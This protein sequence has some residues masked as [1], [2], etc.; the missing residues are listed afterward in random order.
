[1]AGELKP[2]VV[3]MDLTLPRMDGYEAAPLIRRQVP[4][5][6]IVGMSMHPREEVADLVK[7]SGY[8]DYVA[9]DAPWEEMMAVINGPSSSA[10]PS[11]R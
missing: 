5:A 3:L 9:K 10:P 1:M 2:D 8:S 11:R 6:R 4:E 7:R